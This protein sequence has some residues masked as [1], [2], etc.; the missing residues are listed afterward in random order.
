MPRKYIKLHKR[1]KYSEYANKSAE[2]TAQLKSGE[3]NQ[4][5]F[6]RAH[7]NLDE[8]YAWIK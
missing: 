7:E 1:E 6:N 8:K 4:E 2:L 5:Q 3:L